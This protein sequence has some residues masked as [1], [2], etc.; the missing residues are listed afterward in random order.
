MCFSTVH[1]TFSIYKGSY[2]QDSSRRNYLMIYPSRLLLDS[3][4]VTTRNRAIAANDSLSAQ[5]IV[6]CVCCYSRWSSNPAF[7]QVV[8]PRLAPYGDKQKKCRYLLIHLKMSIISI[9]QVPKHSRNKMQKYRNTTSVAGNLQN[10]LVCDALLPA[11]E[12]E[13]TEPRPC[14]HLFLT[15][16]EQSMR[17]TN[18]SH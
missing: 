6:S 3:N 8:F 11:M 15:L 1:V 17:A 2:H 7:Y 10:L 9:A 12:L 14:R 16:D 4:N 18:P 5:S 13:L